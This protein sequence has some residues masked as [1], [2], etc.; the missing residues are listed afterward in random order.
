MEI[1]IKMPAAMLEDGNSIP[2]IGL[3]T[4]SVVGERPG[5]AGYDAIKAAIECGYRHLDTAALYQNEEA[6]GRVIEDC[7]RQGL[8][9]REELY[10]CTKVWCTR[11]KRESVMRACKESLRKLRLDYVD[12]YLIHWPVAYVED[13]D[14]INPKDP[15]TGK[16][17]YSDTHYTETWLGMQD[18]KDAGLAR[19]IGVSNFNREMCDTI[20]DMPRL[21]HRIAVNQV[22]CHPYLS[23]EK[24]LDY[25]NKRAIVLTAYCPLGSPGS[26]AKPGQPAILDDALVR[27]LAVKYKKTPAQICV[28]YQ[29]DRGVSVIPKSV[30]AQRIRE[31]VDV[32]DFK[33][34]DDDM[35]RLLAINRNMRYCVDTAGELVHDHPLYPFHSEF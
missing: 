27:E 13:G 8:V 35:R 24:L 29:L 17:L 31:N 9:R 5:D 1:A 32:L 12:L 20:L 28:R 3:G 2:L 19:S 7:I 6:V 25:S 10:I 21:K 22:E 4:S 23:Q 33:L 11:H 34:S 16:L 14:E 18:V 30:N 26:C 15:K